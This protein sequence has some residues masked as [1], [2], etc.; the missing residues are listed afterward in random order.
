MKIIESYFPI[1]CEANSPI[2]YHPVIEYNQNGHEFCWFNW[3]MTYGLLPVECTDQHDLY[4]YI[5][6]YTMARNV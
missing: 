5:H 2:Y 3:R 1:I 6:A 4:C